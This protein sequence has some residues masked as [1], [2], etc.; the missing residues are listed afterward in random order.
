MAG[1]EL[2]GPGGPGPAFVERLGPGPG[3]WAATAA[4]AMGIGISVY[5]VFGPAVGLLAALG[6]GALLGLALS[7][8]AAEVRVEDGHLVAGDARIP[9]ADL[10]P[11]RA[12]DAE[13]ARRVRGPESDP[14]GYHLIRPSV[15]TGVVAEVVDPDDPTPYW[16][17]ASRSPEQLAAAIEAARAD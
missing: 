15:R 3:L 10:G 7:R 16:F 11:A 2:G 12:L 9:V 8:T 4:L 5:A 1:D 14:A 17:V 13:E 6:P